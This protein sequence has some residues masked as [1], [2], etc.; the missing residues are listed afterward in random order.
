MKEK[1]ITIL[2]GSLFSVSV[3]AQWTPTT[4][5]R[6][7]ADQF[8]LVRH[9][10]KLDLN[11]IKMQLKDARES[12]SNAQP[13]IISL[14]TLNGKIERFAVYSFPVVVKELAD[15]YQLGSY[16]G[17]G[18]DDPNKYLRFS[19]SPNDFQS[20]IIKNG[21]SEFIEPQNTAKTV[22]GVHPK[23]IHTE[24]SRFVCSTNENPKA[25]EQVKKL[26]GNGKSFA[27]QPTDF[28]KSSDK[29][30]RTLRLAMSVT[31]E[32]TQFH[33]G[34]VAGALSAINATLTRANG[35]FE[36]DFALHLNLQNFP[37][38]IY[39]DPATD[40]YSPSDIGADGSWSLEL[41]NTLTA[42]VGDANYDIGHLFAASGGG[43]FA[44]CIGCIC[45]EPGNPAPETENGKGSAYTS[46]ADDIPQ[47]DTFDIDYVSHE[48]GHQLGANHT[49][50]S[51]LEELGVSVEPGTGSTI[52]GYAGMGDVFD[53]VQANTDAYFH[54]A[55]IKQVQAN[56]INKTCD[57][58]TTVAN[59][60]PVI[61]ALPTYHIPKGTAFVLT[62]SA[63]DAEND[64]L[65]FNW[66]QVDDA[67][68]IINSNNLG[69][70]TSGASFRSVLPSTNP[71][72]YFPKL[73]SV[74]AGVLD[75][76]T[77]GW[78][79]VSMVPRT[80]NFAVTVR[81]NSP[82]ANQQQTQY[83]E[84]EIVVGDDGPFTINSQYAAAGGP[85][86]IEWEVANTAAAPYNVTD[87]KIDYTTDNG[88]TW[89][90]LIPSTANDGSESLVFPSS[91]DGQT[92][93]LR[94]SAIGNVFYAVKLI[95]VNA[96]VACDGTAPVGVATSNITANSVDVNWMSISGATYIVRYKKIADTIWQEVAT[97]SASITLSGLDDE[98]AYEVQ[99]AAVCSGTT[100]NYSA[101]SNFTTMNIPYCVAFT[102]NATEE[103]IAN[104]S[105]ANVNNSS[106][107]ST[108]T[109]YSTD[110]ALQ[111]NLMVGAGYT[112]SVTKGWVSSAPPSGVVSAWIDFNRNGVFEDS[113]R[114]LISP[115]GTQNPVTSSFTVPANAVTGAGL[116]MRVVML[117]TN[118]S[119]I[120]LVNPC[121]GPYNAYG[122]VEDYKVVVSPDTT[123]G[124]NNIASP[125]HGIQLYPNPVLDVL[126]IANVSD[127]AVYRIYSGAGQLIK[128][129][130]INDGKIN[131]SSLIR[132]VY[133]I[134]IDDKGRDVF[135]SK[136]IKK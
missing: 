93:T 132:G 105:L 116:R 63:T 103:H 5:Q 127:K 118:L 62:A 67:S 45:L 96:L 58:E 9:Y 131:V 3:F 36:K 7:S 122:E 37:D 83:G 110:S 100:G 71:T 124:I 79:S 46:P 26:F 123:L 59:N 84:Q 66:E 130:N 27:N 48:F 89:I 94:I 47:G 6:K 80:T 87:V 11:T 52:M 15:K 85:Y 56:L 74:L 133:V 135:K 55:S 19:V 102:G 65:T 54:I 13:V 43:G 61:A 70:T 23:T 51:N 57:V 90:I 69:T 4:F 17:V 114:I 134:T 44:G 31:G 39:T 113:E 92:V 12:G 24:G 50:S 106:S 120:G 38:V 64:P 72:R 20:M 115:T 22:Y 76:S 91:L 1:I 32:Y 111:V 35:V 88:G 99:V 81:D 53:N 14:P 25:V 101:S 95:S 2:L 73:S 68:V 121:G 34:T 136:F 86:V 98:L 108:Y 107:A 78:E 109:D 97:S 40:P 28:S 117:Y 8:S 112:L 18:I 129:G 30:Y 10:Y 41:Q 82:V 126:H 42:N 125:N 128:S 119:G 49:F 60:P 21:I 16:A 29:K 75:N 104:V 33:G 77:N